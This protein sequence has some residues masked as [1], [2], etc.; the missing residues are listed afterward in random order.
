LLYTPADREEF[1]HI[2]QK[3]LFEIINNIIS[4]PRQIAEK[5]NH[6]LQNIADNHNPKTA[7]RQLESIYDEALG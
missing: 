3:N 7:A 1:S 6:S 4:N 5:G 2:I